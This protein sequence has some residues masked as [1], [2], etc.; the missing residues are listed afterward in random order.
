MQATVSHEAPFAPNLEPSNAENTCPSSSGE[1]N[2]PQVMLTN[3]RCLERLNVDE[4]K[5]GSCSGQRKC[6]GGEIEVETCPL[7]TKGARF[8]RFRKAG[9]QIWRSKKACQLD[10]ILVVATVITF[11][12]TCIP[13]IVYFALEVSL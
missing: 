3:V 12:L 2:S 8:K 5:T 6:Q 10:A 13:S 7:K 9:S 4:E 1:S 11:F